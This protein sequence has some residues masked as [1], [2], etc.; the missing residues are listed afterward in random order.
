ML[1]W[2][3]SW[4]M[5]QVK[6]IVER[7]STLVY[8]GVEFVEFP[9]SDANEF[10]SESSSSSWQSHDVLS[11]LLHTPGLSHILVS[12]SL[13]S[14]LGLSSLI[15]RTYSLQLFDCVLLQGRVE[16][17]LLGTLLHWWTGLALRSVF[18]TMLHFLTSTLKQR[19]RRR[20]KL[21]NRFFSSSKHFSTFSV[22]HSGW[23]SVTS[24][25]SMR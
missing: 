20:M 21:E 4:S 7:A 15:S 18:L 11:V 10:V 25:Y 17:S 13:H 8:T 14:S 12:L 5:R 23:S 9:I 1:R 2:I 22:L 3:W 16:H 24:W 19:F 6:M